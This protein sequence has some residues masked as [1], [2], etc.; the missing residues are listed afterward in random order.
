MMGGQGSP[1]D[2]WESD[3]ILNSL[4]FGL[5]IINAVSRVTA[6]LYTILMVKGW[7]RSQ[8]RSMQYLRGRAGL[9]PR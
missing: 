8:V 9:G 7:A 1:K 4:C 6:E 5:V 2:I 3:F